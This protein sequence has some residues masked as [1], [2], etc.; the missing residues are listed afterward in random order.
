MVQELPQNDSFD[1]GGLASGTDVFHGNWIRIRPWEGNASFTLGTSPTA[2]THSLYCGLG[3]LH[4]GYKTGQRDPGF[5]GPYVISS[6]VMQRPAVF[7]GDG[8]GAATPDSALYAAVF[9]QSVLDAQSSPEIS[10]A[11]VVVTAEFKN[12]DYSAVPTTNNTLL[13][14]GVIA[15]YRQSTIVDGAATAA[16]LGGANNGEASVMGTEHLSGGSCYMA[17]FF[18]QPGATSRHWAIL[19]VVNGTVTVLASQRAP[20]Q[21]HLTFANL[22]RIELRVS[23]GGSDGTGGAVSLQLTIYDTSVIQ[24]I[25]SSTTTI[26]LTASDNASPLTLVGRH[27][28]FSSRPRNGQ[29]ALIDNVQLTNLLPLGGT[30]RE[31]WYRGSEGAEQYGYRT[32]ADDLGV[33]GRNLHCRYVGDA[34]SVAGLGWGTTGLSA[35]RALKLDTVAGD[36]RLTST[37]AGATI[38]KSDVPR[39]DLLPSLSSTADNRSCTFIVTNP[40]VSGTDGEVTIAARAKLDTSATFDA[41]KWLRGTV[42]VSL[43]VANNVGTPQYFLRV[44]IVGNTAVIASSQTGALSG[45]ALNLPTSWT[46]N[47][48]K[49]TM[50]VETYSPDTLSVYI[51]PRFGENAATN[52]YTGSSTSGTGVS[53]VGGQ[54]T[55]FYTGGQWADT[56]SGSHAAFLSSGGTSIAS[57]HLDNNWR[58]GV[59]GSGLDLRMASQFLYI[60]SRTST[61]L[62]MASQFLYIVS[63]TDTQLRMASQ[64]LYIVSRTQPQATAVLAF[65]PTFTFSA[66][67]ISSVDNTTNLTVAGPSF[68]FTGGDF[69]F[70]S[71]FKPVIIVE[72]PAGQ[73]SLSGVSCATM[74]AAGVEAGQIT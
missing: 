28:V 55:Y 45:T 51:T 49:I 26:V 62:R 38:P 54:F 32:V 74:V 73:I 9:R 70:T 35:N 17:G 11:N 53:F 5:A 3:T 43:R 60:V 40:S 1:E 37:S 61:Q 14:A 36:T 27:G 63:R 16:T 24:Q 2:V 64:F 6:I 69:E 8:Y 23:G 57:S 31:E 58:V 22:R 39:I 66:G 21:A 29:V 71:I 46:N 18:Q 4:D 25:G 72:P 30:T 48:V 10:F 59:L 12:L 65:G 68:F 52:L 33:T 41:T 15:R 42:M 20:Q 44:Q 34:Y 13:Y 56:K 47:T 50:A 7:Y 67:A 19:K